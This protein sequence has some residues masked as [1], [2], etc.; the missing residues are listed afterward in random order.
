M[1]RTARDAITDPENQVAVSAASAWEISI[2]GS[3]GRLSIPDDLEEV[4][5]AS[6]FEA[7][8]ITVGHALVAGALPSHHRDPFDR[9]L[10]A[11]ALDGGFTVM[12]HDLA[13]GDYD[14]PVLF[15]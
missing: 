3:L 5:E 14:V 15:V 8:P 2:K 1:S 9:M 10:V 13:F 11:Q 12:T 7:L 4:L 6:G